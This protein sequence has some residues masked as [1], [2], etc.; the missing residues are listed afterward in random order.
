MVGLTGF[1]V[2]FGVLVVQMATE[3]LSPRFMRLWYRDGLQKAVLGMF[4]GTLTF[5]LA[6]LRGVGPDTVPD[7]GVT[8]AALAV[9][10]S[11]VLFLVYL[12]RFVHNLRPV[13]VAW[14]VAAAGA[15]V[16]RA[17]EPGARDEPPDAPS[18]P[19]A[20]TV[21]VAD[22]GVIQ[23][24]DHA[25][26]VATATRHDCLIVS[27]HAIGDLVPHGEVLIEVHGAGT[28]PEAGRCGEWPRSARSARSSRTPRSPCGSSSTSRSGRCRPRSTTRRRRS[29]C[30]ARSRICCCASAR[31]ISRAGARCATPAGTPAC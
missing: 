18:G 1:V 23:A 13:A 6:L 16:F 7:A 12:D 27:P 3:T 2:A 31:A 25:G 19:P 8:L 22:A 29:R 24:I 4:V 5:S 21:R 14:G 11:V 9:T 26:L 20:L 15:R 30:W 10:V 28:L 17:G